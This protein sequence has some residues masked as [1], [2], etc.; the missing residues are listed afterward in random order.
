M[1]N[2]LETRIIGDL[3]FDAYYDEWATNPIEDYNDDVRA[4][5]YLT[6]Y[7]EQDDI[8]DMQRSCSIAD[9]FATVWEKHRDDTLALAV[10]RRHARVALGWDETTANLSIQTFSHKGYSQGDWREYLMVDYSHRESLG[11]IFHTFSLYLQGD[12]YMVHVSERVECEQPELCHGTDASHWEPDEAYYVIYADTA[13][14]AINS[15]TSVY[16]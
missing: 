14:E 5:A 16:F 9:A 12:V 11:A 15:I 2:L 7:L 4:W 10:A 13:D 1:N 3:K 6:P 8:N